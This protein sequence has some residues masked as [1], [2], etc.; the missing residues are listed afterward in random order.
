MI[1]LV[2]NKENPSEILYLRSKF[3]DNFEGLWEFIETKPDE[4]DKIK[5][6]E[7]ATATSLFAGDMDYHGGDK[8]KNGYITGNLGLIKDNEG[9]YITAKIDHGKSGIVFY[10]NES[11]LRQKILSNHMN[12]FGP[13]TN[14]DLIFFKSAIDEITKTTINQ[15][16]DIIKT[17]T[18]NLKNNGFQPNER[19]YF[20][21]DG[22]GEDITVKDM[23]DL[24]RIYI[25]NYAQQLVTMKN[26]ST[27]LDIISK[28]DMPDNWKKKDWLEDIAGKEPLEY[29]L[30]NDIRIQ[31]MH[32][33]LWAE[34]NEITLS[35]EII[36]KKP[37]L[38]SNMIDQYCKLKNSSLKII[39]SKQEKLLKKENLLKCNQLEKDYSLIFT[40]SLSN[41]TSKQDKILDENSIISKTIDKN[42]K[43]FVRLLDEQIIDGKNPLSKSNHMLNVMSLSLIHKIININQE[44]STRKE[45]DTS[46]L[47]IQDLFGRFANA[48]KILMRVSITSK[49]IQDSIA[50]YNN[51]S[52]SKSR[53]PG[54]VG[55]NT[56]EKKGG[57]RKNTQALH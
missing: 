17:R 22:K 28:F 16:E 5:G 38:Q 37:Q 1:E 39:Q 3:L 14:F 23:E 30:D 8:D 6:L 53:A 2:E 57:G 47:Y 33:L 31:G 45:A 12:Y 34:K 13:T 43:A 11:L 44:L 48:I 32:A 51:K 9:N 54:I 10:D 49:D 24:E 18:H 56:K 15:I 41:T 21:K 35:N 29:A 55:Q 25:K 52:D 36:E 27:S 50:E 20:E 40:N 46:V 4:I 42:P 19:L 26:L 7:K